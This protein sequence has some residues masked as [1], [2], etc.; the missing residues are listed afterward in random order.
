MPAED[1]PRLSAGEA[2]IEGRYAAARAAIRQ[3]A[4]AVIADVE[5]QADR[6][7][8]VLMERRVRELREWRAAQVRAM[9]RPG[10]RL[11]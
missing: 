4:D 6:A 1:Y 11:H 8:T 10:Q 2:E 7:A 5:A 9:R 3:K